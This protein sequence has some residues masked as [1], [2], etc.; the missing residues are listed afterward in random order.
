MSSAFDTL[1]AIQAHDT[2]LDQIRHQLAGLAERAARDTASDAVASIDG[3]IAGVTSARGDLARRQKRL[4]DEIETIAAKRAH[5]EET[6]Y[7]GSVTN[8]RALQ[9]LQE[10]IE[11]LKRR[12]SDLEDQ[13]LE[14]M[15]QI[16]PLDARLAELAES[17][18]EAVGVLEG[19][20]VA[21]TAAE[22]ELAVALESEQAQRDDLTPGV[23]STLLSEYESLRAARGGVGVARLSGT[24]CGGC[25][26]ALSAV[27]VSRIRKLADGEV[28][29]CEECGRLLVP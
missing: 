13:D 21:L 4:D 29:H 7:G 15:E 20:E 26:L 28:T 5:E 9:D 8:A 6:L 11:S 14:I 1:L 18:D 24:Q 16:E 25:H 3:E 17:R 19:C 27:E 10:E 2:R 23:D 22:A 12:I